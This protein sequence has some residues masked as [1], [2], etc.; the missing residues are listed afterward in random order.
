MSKELGRIH[1]G[2]RYGPFPAKLAILNDT[3]CIHRS[4]IAPIALHYSY[5]SVYPVGCE[6]LGP[7]TMSSFQF[8]FICLR[9]W[10]TS[11]GKLMNVIT[12]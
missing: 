8:C 6:P 7:G 12:R 11:G 10:K 2:I 9:G 5:L 4:I 3:I 1:R